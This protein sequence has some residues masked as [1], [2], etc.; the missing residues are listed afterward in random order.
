MKIVL[1]QQHLLGQLQQQVS[2]LFSSALQL[3]ASHLQ[4]TVHLVVAHLQL[5][6]KYM[7]I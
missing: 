4:S 1:N 7:E 5:S 2:L 3:H 6:S